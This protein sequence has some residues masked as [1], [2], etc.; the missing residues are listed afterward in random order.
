MT[1]TGKGHNSHMYPV[2]S[3]VF[4]D[5]SIRDLS[6]FGDNNYKNVLAAWDDMAYGLEQDDGISESLSLQ[7]HHK[8]ATAASLSHSDGVYMLFEDGTLQVRERESVA[9]SHVIIPLCAFS[10]TNC[11]C[12][13]PL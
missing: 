2:L 3:C 11:C 12:D 5:G 9:N 8:V 6:F 4:E 1:D 10:P 13:I 7:G